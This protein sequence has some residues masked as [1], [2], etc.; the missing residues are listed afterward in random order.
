MTLLAVIA[1]FQIFLGLI[2]SCNDRSASSISF[3]WLL[4]RRPASEGFLQGREKSE[5]P[6]GADAGAL[7]PL[8][9]RLRGLRQDRLPRSD[10]QSA[11]FG[12]GM[13][14]FRGGMRCAD[15]GHPR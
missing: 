1:F 2:R 10:P 7:V 13:P 6:A 5:I 11:P 3:H 8:Q 15:G 9:P 14:G 12:A 4:H